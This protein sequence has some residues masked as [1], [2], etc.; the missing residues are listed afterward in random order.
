MNIS[1][2]EE[3]ALDFSASGDSSLSFGW[4]DASPDNGYTVDFSLVLGDGA[5]GG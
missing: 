4:G 1:L 5:T 3:G 2:T